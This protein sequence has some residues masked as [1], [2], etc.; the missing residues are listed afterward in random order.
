VGEEKFRE[1]KVGRTFF[2]YRKKFICF[3]EAIQKTVTNIAGG[4]SGKFVRA[5]QYQRVSKK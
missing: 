2:C 1:E 3:Q 4:C 5:F